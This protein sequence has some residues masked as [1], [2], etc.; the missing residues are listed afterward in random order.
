MG[1]KCRDIEGLPLTSWLKNEDFVGK[2]HMYK[3]YYLNT[4]PQPNGDYEVHTED[5]SYL[6]NALNRI[7]LGYY[8][9]CMD[10]VNAAKRLGYT[11]A[12]GCYWCSY[13]CHTS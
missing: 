3:N 1:Q 6:P 13:S 9:D 12:N 4:K 2:M 7:Y 5:C 8:S 10:A 11:K